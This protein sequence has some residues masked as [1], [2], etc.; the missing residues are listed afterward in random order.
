LN[1]NKILVLGAGR[2]GAWFIDSLCLDYDVAVFDID[3]TRLRYLFNCKRLTRFEE[4]QEFA[5]ELVIN[6]VNLQLTVKVF[7][8]VLPYLPDDCLLSD[9]TSVKTP[10]REFYLNSTR[11]FV[12]THPMF[13]PT[14]ANIKDLSNQNAIIIEQS[15]EEGKKFFRKFY[16]QFNIKV[17]EYTFIEHDKTIAYS[18]SVPF[19]SSMV[20]ASNMKHQ[21]APGTTFKKHYKI[22][23]GVLSEDDYL[24]SEILFS[25]YTYE[26]IDGIS[27]KLNI[28]KDIIHNRD[29]GKMK[30]FLAQLRENIDERPQ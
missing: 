6:A 1:I 16:K 22:A 8:E 24:L 10:M 18:L 29:I 20:F 13:G 28:L 23:M 30:D 19:A 25:P 27:N 7:E 21:E 4:I 3:K 17:F 15:D 14:F 5:P 11:R 26:Q 2:M 12:S 9:I